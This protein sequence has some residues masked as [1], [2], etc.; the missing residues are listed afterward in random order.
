MRSRLRHKL[1][2][3][4]FRLSP[5]LAER[6]NI[7]FRLATPS[8]AFMENEIFSYVNRLAG[9][10]SQRSRLL[11]LGMDRYNWHYP[12][13]LHAV[14]FHSIDIRPERA[15]YG[16][17]GRH[18]VGDVMDMAGHYGEEAFDIVIANG[19]LGFGV[20]TRHAMKMLLAQCHGVLKPGGLLVLG[21]N[22]RAD[23]VPFPV[24]LDEEMFDEFAPPIEGVRESRHMVDD[25]YKHL[26]VFA[27]KTA[28]D[29]QADGSRPAVAGWDA[30]LKLAPLAT[31]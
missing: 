21:F 4:I 1:N 19:L 30:P 14:E 10:T 20:N 6:C 27:G 29:K 18:V 15:K 17:P 12:R 8:R 26:Y 5:A 13:L 3:V 24:T 11:F 31:P 23:I 25:A 28:R 22:A 9:A 16:P 2:K 7:D